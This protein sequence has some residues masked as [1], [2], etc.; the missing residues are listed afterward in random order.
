MMITN[1][2]PLSYWRGSAI[3]K[4]QPQEVVLYKNFSIN[5]FKLK[6][7]PDLIKE[8]EN[9]DDSGKLAFVVGLQKDLLKNLALFSYTQFDDSNGEISCGYSLR[10]IYKKPS[11]GS[12]IS[13]EIYLLARVASNSDREIYSL[14]ENQAKYIESSLRSQLYKFGFDEQNQFNWQPTWLNY[15]QPPYCYEIIKNEEVF[16]WLEADKKYFYSPGNFQ[17]NNRNNMIALYEQLQAYSED[18]C[19]DITLVPTTVEPYEK[20]TISRYI[21]A[22]AVAARGVHEEKINPDSNA[23]KVKSVYE[24]ITKKYYYGIVFLSSLRVFSPSQYI[25][26]SVANQLAASCIANTVNPR[27]I[28]V[29]DRKYAVQ[30][31]LQVNVNDKACVA[32]M[33]DITGNKPDGF[34]GGPETLRRL[35]RLIDLDEASAFFRLPIPINQVC[36]GVPCN[37][38]IVSSNES[39]NQLP[40]IVPIEDLIREHGKLITED[41]Y[42]VGIDPNAKPCVSNLMNIAHRLIAG[43]PGAGKTNFINSV[44]YQFLYASQ[45]IKAERQIYIVDFQAG[46]YFERIAKAH[47]NVKLVTEFEQF[48]DVLNHLIEVYKKRRQ[49]LRDE[50]VEN[51]K[52]LR[53][54]CNSNEHRI[55]LVIDEAAS[56]LDAERK[57]KENINSALR[58]LTLKARATD[59]NIFFCTQQPTTEV[60][61]GQILNN[62]DERVIFR[63]QSTVSVRLL[64]EDIAA[65]LPVNPKGRAIYRDLG[66]YEPEL[67]IVATPYVPKDVWNKPFG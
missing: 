31:A 63:V 14:K 51:L 10:I 30:T 6:A 49:T 3:M 66:G 34:Q 61:E 54:K 22:L 50:D 55:M 53:E 47:P 32:G 24:E 46:L 28:Q 17:A 57:I 9:L 21:E 26:Q 29:A 7:V 48:L 56:I 19:I 40:E 2:P 1:T 5:I 27:L 67:K 39:A 38:N 60:I 58:T 15:S 59:I 41:T 36:P 65:S 11:Q 20:N 42:I 62:M 4:G 33:W 23:K 64:D 16:Q 43:V 8:I 12:Q 35:H 13:T 25:C 52:E 44:I 45:K 37:S 18:V